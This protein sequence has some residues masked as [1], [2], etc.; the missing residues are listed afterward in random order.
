MSEE[1]EVSHSFLSVLLSIL[2][3]PLLLTALAGENIKH[4]E[5]ILWVFRAE[6]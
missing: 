5:A 4:T 1:V 6:Q 2:F 3:A